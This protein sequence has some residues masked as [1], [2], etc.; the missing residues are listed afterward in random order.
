MADAALWLPSHF[1]A[2][3][4]KDNCKNAH[5]HA[6]FAFPSEFPYEFGLSSP[7]LESFAGSTGTESSDGE[8]DFFAGLSRRLSQSS[9]NEPRK[10]LSAMPIQP[11]NGTFSEIPRKAQGLV[12]SPQSTLTG[13][14][15]W[16]GRSAVSGDGS[17]NGYSRVPSPSTT[18]FDE[19]NDPWEV[20]YAAAGQ[21][22]R[23][24]INNNHVSQ[25]DFQNSRGSVTH[26]PLNQS[27]NQ[28]ARPKQQCGSVW[29]RPTKPNWV[30]Q[31]QQVQVQNRAR[32]FGHE[33]VNVKCTR[34][35]SLPQSAW[36]PLQVQQQNNR[37]QYGGS[38]SRVAVPGTGGGSSVKR[39]CGGTGV[40]LPR[41]YETT[42]SESRKKTGCG[43]VLLPAKVAHALNMKMDDLNGVNQQR[44]SS[45]F[46]SD[47][48]AI[49]AR[50]KAVLMQQR[51]SVGREE[52]ANCEIRLP[53]EWTY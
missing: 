52:A 47:Y 14:G 27:F 37:V 1:L 42:P 22:A 44:F 16:S 50:R 21:V 41:H 24:K 17:P 12:G 31:P 51:L 15:S 45:A 39:G 40:F 29:G 18:P 53:Q 35:T 46:A 30:V 4:T 2:H 43:P 19:N 26:S 13:F 48:E 8:E 20:I 38:G 32:E 9:L 28:V 7:T 34:P 36:P 3:H 11:D 25:Y 49:L 5:F 10:Q 6:P 23:L 33:S